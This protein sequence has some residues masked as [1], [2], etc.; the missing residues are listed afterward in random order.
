MPALAHGGAPRVN[1]VRTTGPLQRA[2]AQILRALMCS[3]TPARIAR[4]AGRPLADPRARRRPRCVHGHIDAAQEGAPRHCA[5][6]KD[7]RSWLP[8]QYPPA[9]RFHRSL[10]PVGAVCLFASAAAG[11]SQ[12]FTGSRRRPGSVGTLA[13]T[14]ERRI[15]DLHGFE[16]WSSTLWGRM[17]TERLPAFRGRTSEREVLD[18]LLD[19]VRRGQ[20]AVLV[21]RGEAGVGKTALLRYAARQAA[22]F[23]VAQIAGV[24]SEMELPFAGLHQ[25]CAPM[26]D[27]LDALPEPQQDALQVAFGLSSGDAPDRFLVGL[28]TLSLLSEVA[29]ERPLLC[30]RRRRAVARRRLEPGPGIRGPTAAGGVGGDR[31]RGSRAERRARA[32][33]PAGVA[34]HGAAGGRCARPAGGHHPGPTRRPRPRPDRRRNARQPAGPAGAAEGHQRSASWRVALRFRRGDLPGQIEDHYL[35]AARRLARGDAATDAAGRGRPGWRRR[36]SS[37]VPPSRSVSNRGRP[38]RRRATSCW[39]SAPRVRFRHPLVRSAVYRAASAEDRR[40]AHGALAAATDPEADP[41]RRAWHRAHA[42]DRPGRGGGRRIAPSA[43]T[44]PSAAAASPPP[45]RSWS[46]RWR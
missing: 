36:R 3:R 5:S 38:S 7:P 6:A 45:P 1:H 21:I 33:G 30:A 2:A 31:L 9:H 15:G 10:R 25:L 37:G 35:A 43:P 8:Q 12:A 41:D 11:G 4:W 44:V 42:A 27:Q 26:L 46:G 23:R 29:E 14:A 19:S 40:A 32:G 17:A 24:E 22:G 13:A 39:R 16:P 18:R 20:S 34:A 28:A